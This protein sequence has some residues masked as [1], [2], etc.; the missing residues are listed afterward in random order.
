MEKRREAKGIIAATYKQMV[1]QERSADI[2]IKNIAEES[3]VSRKTFYYH[4]PDK[5]HLMY[6]IFRSELAERLRLAF[7][8]SDLLFPHPDMRDQCPDLPFYGRIQSGV[9]KIDGSLFFDVLGKYLQGNRDYYRLAFQDED[10]FGF[11]RSIV[12]LYHYA[13]V[14]DI[15]FILGGRFLPNDVRRRLAMYFSSA[16]VANY[17]D[18]LLY[19]NNDLSKI[20]PS[21]F[22]NINHESLCAAIERHFDRDSHKFN[23]L[24]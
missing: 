7:H 14:C 4:F 22:S 11:K 12:R 5:S 10:F 24:P 6:W 18:A 1:L 19:S 16:A 17:F 8:E 20:I 2:P 9:R 13:F 3:G 21:G 23:L 15:N